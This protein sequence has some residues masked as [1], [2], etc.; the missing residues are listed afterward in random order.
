MALACRLCKVPIAASH[1]CD[2]CETMRRNLTVVGEDEDDRPSLSG[3]AA[4]VV[5]VLRDQTVNVRGRLKLN[6]LSM[7]DEKRALALGNTLAKVLESSRK[8][9][10]DGKDA[11]EN[12]S[13]QERAELF[14]TWYVA[15]PPAYRQN[16]RDRFADY[17]VQVSKPLAA[18]EE[19]LK[20]N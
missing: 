11:V 16:V 6:P 7:V 8:L 13:F 14:V 15:L 17:E 9:M 12:M 3:T 19:A 18:S 1:G 10:Q 2:V 5:A 20:G 4:E